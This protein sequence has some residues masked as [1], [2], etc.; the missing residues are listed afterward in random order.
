M[1]TLENNIKKIKEIVQL[2]HKTMQRDHLQNV[3]DTSRVQ[4]QRVCDQRD[5]KRTRTGMQ[6]QL[7][8]WDATT[9]DWIATTTDWTGSQ[10]PRLLREGF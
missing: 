1:Q 4:D 3:Y 6:Q 5:K 2:I 8:G 10:Y 7:I 9:T